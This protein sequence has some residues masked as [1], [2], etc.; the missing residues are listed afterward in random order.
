[1][2]SKSSIQPGDIFCIEIDNAYK[3]YLQYIGDD[4]TNANRS[5]V[6]VFYSKYPIREVV[7]LN[8]VI[9]DDKFFWT[10]VFIKNDMKPDELYNVGNV[11]ISDTNEFGFISCLRPKEYSRIND[12]DEFGC[13]WLWRMNDAPY[14]TFPVPFNLIDKLEDGESHHV[15]EIVDRIIL[16]YYRRSS[17]VYDVIKRKPLPG[18]H[19]YLKTQCVA[20][21]KFYH[22]EGE[23]LV[24]QI[25]ISKADG[26]VKTNELIGEMKFWDENW[27]EEDFIYPRQFELAWIKYHPKNPVNAISR[28]IYKR[29]K[30]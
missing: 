5:V 16:G 21:I 10:C 18:V 9:S 26:S 24:R 13:W 25:T 27:T 8:K 19:S 6:K 11:K 3:C 4:E 15:Y 28:I 23:D 20:D 14:M 7:D 17:P 1:M 30:S 12:K 29:L 22:F 2:K